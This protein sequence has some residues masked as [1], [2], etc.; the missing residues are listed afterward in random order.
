VRWRF[1]GYPAQESFAVLTQVRAKQS[2]QLDDDLVGDLP[3]NLPTCPTGSP[4]SSHCSDQGSV[5]LLGLP[6]FLDL[7]RRARCVGRIGSLLFALLT[8]VCGGAG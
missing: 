2:E 7:F 8:Y 1:A 5:T 4:V 6:F 3:G